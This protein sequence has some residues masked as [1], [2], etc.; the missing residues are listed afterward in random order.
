MT[1]DPTSDGDLDGSDDAIALLTSDHEDVKELFAEYEDLVNDGDSDEDR[2]GLADQICLALTAHATV[3]EE[4]FYPAVRAVLADAA[5]IDEAVAEHA[6]AKTLIAQL[7]AM[8]AD[9]KRFDSTV[10]LLQEAVLHHVDDEEGR[11]FPLV[12]AQQLDLQALGERMAKR[13]Q[14]VLAD[15]EMES[16]PD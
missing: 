16:D 12:R 15:L 3:E 7:Q 8:E 2:I 11:L 4:I 13:K 10:Q 14:E 9:D 1:P 6:Q 5:L